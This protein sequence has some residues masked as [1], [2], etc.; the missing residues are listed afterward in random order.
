M[1]LGMN[2]KQ[3]QKAGMEDGPTVRAAPIMLLILPIILFRIAF[4]IHLLFQNYSQ[5]LPIIPKLST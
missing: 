3:T 4:K 5:L 1:M 2:K